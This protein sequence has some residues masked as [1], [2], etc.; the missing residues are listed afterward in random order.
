MSEAMPAGRQE[1][2]IDKDQ[3]FTE[4]E[5][6][7]ATYDYLPFLTAIDYPEKNIIEMVYRLQS[8]ASNDVLTIKVELPREAAEVRSLVSLWPAADWHEREVFDLFGV[9]FIGHSDL[10]RILL[11]PD[12]VGHPLLKDYT[13][14]KMIKKPVTI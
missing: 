1:R 12:W 5:K 6:L 7:K 3:L 14:S 11:P 10:R 4:C 9:K 2:K 13:D 8:T